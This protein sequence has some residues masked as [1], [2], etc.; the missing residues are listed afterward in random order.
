VAQH[1]R[2]TETAEKRYVDSHRCFHGAEFLF[3]AAGRRVEEIAIA[4]EYVAAARAQRG[5]AVLPHQWREVLAA[6]VVV[7]ESGVEIRFVVG[8]RSAHRD[9]ID[10]VE[11][12]PHLRDDAIAVLDRVAELTALQPFAAHVG[13]FA[14]A[15]NELW[16]VGFVD[17]AADEAG[18]DGDRC[19]NDALLHHHEWT[20]DDANGFQQAK[21]CRGDPRHQ[22]AWRRSFR[23]RQHPVLTLRHRC[24]PSRMCDASGRVVPRTHGW[25][26]ARSF[27]VP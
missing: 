20:N 5:I 27:A 6:H 17:K 18:M 16:K 19:R 23:L 22:R 2:A 25:L 15:A 8:Q 7:C 13:V 12:A 10:L 26:R 14:T 4:P 21:R 3:E 24:S 1:E 9:E 11:I